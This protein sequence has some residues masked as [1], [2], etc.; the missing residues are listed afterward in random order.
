MAINK[1]R[2]IPRTLHSLTLFFIAFFIFNVTVSS[3]FAQESVI[4]MPPGYYINTDSGEPR[5]IQ[6]LVWRGGEYAIRYDV[7]VEKFENGRYVQHIR[8]NTTLLFVEVSLQH[9]SYRFQVIPYDFF[10]K[11]GNPSQWMYVEVLQAVQPEPAR[12]L[13]E[14]IAGDDGEPIGFYLTI[15]GNN[16]DPFA[17]F[18]LQPK[19]GLHPE[20]TQIYL[21]V[22]DVGA[23]GSVKVLINNANIDFGEYDI[24]IRNPG[25][26]EAKV[27]SMYFENEIAS[28]VYETEMIPEE[29]EQITQESDQLK[30]DSEEIFEETKIA[31]TELTEPVLEEELNTTETAKIDTENYDLKKLNNVLLWGGISWMPVIP[32]Y[33]F[34]FGTKND[35]VGYSL[36]VGVV[37]K[38]KDIYTGLEFFA[39]FSSSYY[40]VLYTGVNL[41]F[42]KWFSKE[43]VSLTFRG[44]V[45]LSPLEDSKDQYW[46]NELNEYV[47]DNSLTELC[48]NLG[49]SLSLRAT[50]NILL[51]FRLN[52]SHLFSNIPSGNINPW[53]GIT[54]LIN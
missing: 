32:L 18:L 2:K 14:I 38:I 46:N 25:G 19:Q 11:Q 33:G 43:R 34:E 3:L 21:D 1:Q 45:S 53:I 27:G 28:S 31:Q 7:I 20:N 22:V 52:Y 8:E 13:S 12:V 29:T 37:F 40:K 49:L 9:G 36:N 39:S 15:S 44:G 26:L 51:D 50:N 35:M 16:L 23:D 41:L 42:K 6:R 5:F 48:I 30:N 17:E 54:Y 4:S 24:V 10:E 47:S